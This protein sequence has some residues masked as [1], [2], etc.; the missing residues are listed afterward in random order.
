MGR[1]LTQR[2]AQHGVNAALDLR[3]GHVPTLRAEFGV[4]MEKMQ[5]EVQ[6]ITCVDMQEVQPD[7]QKIISSRSFG[8]HSYSSKDILSKLSLEMQLQLLGEN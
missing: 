5:R 1:K 2:L 7:R 4:V 6:E 8:T 3:E